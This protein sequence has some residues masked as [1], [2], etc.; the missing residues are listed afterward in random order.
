MN[1][2]K[3][4]AKGRRRARVLAEQAW[5]A[6]NRGN[7]DLAEKIIRRA[8]ATQE[9][10]PVLWNDQGIILS[11]RRN[12]SEAANSF[13]AALSLAPTFP[14]PYAHL[15][16]LRLRQGRVE[17]AVALQ[18]QAVKHAPHRVPYAEQLQVYQA[19][20]GRLPVEAATLAGATGD[21]SVP[22]TDDG[23]NDWPQRLEALEWYS[24]ANR[25]TRDGYTVIAGLVDAPTCERLR[26]MFEDDQLFSKTVIMDRPEFGNGVYRYFAA[27]LPNVVD[28]LRRA[29]Y[30]HVARIAN[31]W[32]Q[33]LGKEERFPEA[34]DGFRDRCLDAGQ[35]T[36]TP[37]L[38]K[39][40][41]G[42]FNGLHRDVRGAVYFPIQM[43]VV[44]SPRANPEDADTLGFQ[45]GE[46]LFCDYPEGKKSRRQEVPLGLGDAVLFCT[47][48]RLART[49][50]VVG[51]QPVRHGAAPITAGTRFVLGLPFHEYR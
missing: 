42:G 27:P 18:S 31:E 40:G 2:K 10:N 3:Q 13:V 7:L 21:P 49:G 17:E 4:K 14:D 37:I 34:W 36:P 9:D 50:G 19:L 23:A 6:A 15:A 28:H 51:L 39:Y 30:P 24:L 16:T 22:P 46:F 44:L 5:D 26:G 29:V 45:G 25:L 1:P 41:P 47:C 38:L 12:D 48:D 43:A 8:V 35:I 20:S 32:Q 33:M 11:L